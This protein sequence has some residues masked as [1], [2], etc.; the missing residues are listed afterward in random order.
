M[1]RRHLNI[2]QHNNLDFICSQLDN[3]WQDL[4]FPQLNA[5]EL[6]QQHLENL[7]ESAIQKQ[8]DMKEKILEKI[9]KAEQQQSMWCK[10][11]TFVSKKKFTPLM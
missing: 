9:I 8:D 1:H 6:R 4:R 2:V 5:E 11:G 3:A 7:A 10:L